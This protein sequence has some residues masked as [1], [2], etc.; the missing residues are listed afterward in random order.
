VAARGA[1]GIL[2]HGAWPEVRITHCDPLEAG[3]ADMPERLVGGRAPLVRSSAGGVS[4]ADPPA[5]MPGVWYRQRP[6][7]A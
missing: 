3:V 5:N 2:I 4:V 1:P 6:R 7:R